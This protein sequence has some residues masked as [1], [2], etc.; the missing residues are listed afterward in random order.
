MKNWASRRG[1]CPPEAAGKAL[2]Y[3]LPISNN[4]A[5]SDFYDVAELPRLD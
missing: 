3:A 4:G 5:R 2:L 1:K